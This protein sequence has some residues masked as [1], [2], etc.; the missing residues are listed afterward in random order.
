M[1]TKNK[2]AAAA[3]PKEA[4]LTA[5]QKAAATKK[6]KAAAA[7]A[8]APKAKAAAKVP[9]PKA[10]PVEAKA[11]PAKATKAVV[12][13]VAPVVEAVEDDTASI[14]R[15][16]LAEGVRHR[17]Q[18]QGFGVSSS[19]SLAMVQAFEDAVQNAL[20]SGTD[21]TLPGFGKFKV[22][23]RPGGPRRNP[24]D[25]TTM[26][27]APSWAVSFKVGKALKVAANARPTE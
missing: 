17:M 27:V 9:K 16:Q 10:D 6:A 4:E 11:A 15:K 23:Q 26:E 14:G 3:A 13:K 12:A 8:P 2:P 24:R 25:G 21:V 18:E 19:L 7:E 22:A 1:A 20:A 5:G